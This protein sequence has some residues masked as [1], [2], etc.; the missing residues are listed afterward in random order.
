LQ[1]NVAATLARLIG[2]IAEIDIG[3]GHR[4]VLHRNESQEHILEIVFAE[5]GKVVRL[6]AVFPADLIGRSAEI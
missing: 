3:D 6:L 2:D 1:R 4:Q 5:C